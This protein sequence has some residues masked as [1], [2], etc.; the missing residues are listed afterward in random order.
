MSREGSLFNILLGTVGRLSLITAKHDR[1]M[2]TSHGLPVYPSDSQIPEILPVDGRINILIYL[3]HIGSNIITRAV[4]VTPEVRIPD[5]PSV[6]CDQ[7][8]WRPASAAELFAG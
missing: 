5:S 7:R 2:T 4:I 3:S 1:A 8:R 6:V